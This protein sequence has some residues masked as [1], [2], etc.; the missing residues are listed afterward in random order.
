M[1]GVRASTGST[2]PCPPMN[3]RVSG[4]FQI[5]SSDSA[6]GIPIDSA[7]LTPR[8]RVRALA[9]IFVALVLAL[10]TLGLSGSML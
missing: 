2:S 10:G 4:I 8:P 9:W 7:E 1:G 6:C 3:Q 5:R